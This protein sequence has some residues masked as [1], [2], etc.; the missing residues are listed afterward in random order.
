MSKAKYELIKEI[1][2]HIDIISY[3]LENYEDKYNICNLETIKEKMESVRN[4]CIES[5]FN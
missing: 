3:F 1:E 2:T 5:I 4:I